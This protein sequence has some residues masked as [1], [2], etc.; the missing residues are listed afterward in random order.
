MIQNNL[1]IS[2]TIFQYGTSDQYLLK[3]INSI[4]AHPDRFQEIYKSCSIDPIYQW[5]FLK[6]FPDGYTVENAKEFFFW[7]Q[8]SWKKGTHFVYLLTEM[9]GKIVG[10]IDIRSNNLNKAE[11]GYW[12]NSKHKGLATNAMAQI[13]IIAKSVGYKVLF[14]QV[15]KANTRSIK[16]L[17]RNNFQRDDTFKTNKDC[18]WA[19]KKQL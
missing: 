6:R 10:S 2:S 19:F 16:V 7:A 4:T 14:A 8:E 3:P 1:N 17:E 11:T 15:E 12:I 9:N 13:G 18:D 5:L